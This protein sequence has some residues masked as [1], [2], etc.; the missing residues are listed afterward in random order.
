V[1]LTFANKICRK[2]K[3]KARLLDTDRA[4]R[5][6]RCMFSRAALVSDKKK[7]LAVTLPCMCTVAPTYAKRQPNTVTAFVALLPS[8]SSAGIASSRP[9]RGI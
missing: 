1:G 5:R 3:T 2:A 7:H 8:K 6:T 9:R 4:F